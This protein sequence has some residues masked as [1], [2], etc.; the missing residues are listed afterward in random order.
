MP[1]DTKPASEPS[2]AEKAFAL[3]LSLGDGR[4]YQQVAQ[5]MGVALATVKRWSR[6]GGWQSKVRERDAQAAREVADRFQ[7]GRIAETERNL[8]IV[9]AA[10]MRLAKDIAEGRIKSQLSDLPRLVQLEQD[11]LRPPE[12]TS[13]DDIRNLTD[14]QLKAR[15]REL[16]LSL[17]Q[18]FPDIRD[19][20]VAMAAEEG[21]TKG[22]DSLP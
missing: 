20:I 17:L 7:S 3:F 14:E 11:L 5:R 22:L 13:A 15:S 9:R 18:S 2:R 8:K 16:I 1:T 6:A 19:E 21:R 12:P 10:L 4:T